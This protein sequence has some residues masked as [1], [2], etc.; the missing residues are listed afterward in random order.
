MKITFI[1][2][3]LFLS[4][5][6]PSS[7]KDCFRFTRDESVVNDDGLIRE[8]RR[9]LTTARG[10]E[11]QWSTEQRCSNLYVISLRSRRNLELTKSRL[12]Q[13]RENG[14]NPMI[15]FSTYGGGHLPQETVKNLGLTDQDRIFLYDSTP[16]PE[17]IQATKAMFDR[18]YNAIKTEQ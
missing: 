13:L 5:S 18:L 6:M 10:T 15:I 17:L 2:L 7:A 16:T 3:F 4:F 11:V 14:E 1:S 12:N 9:G 8:L